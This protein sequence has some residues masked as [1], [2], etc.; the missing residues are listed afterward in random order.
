MLPG[1]EPQ[2]Q[3]PEENFLPGWNDEEMQMPQATSVPQTQEEA[4]L[5]GFDEESEEED[6]V[7]PGLERQEPEYEKPVVP[8][9]NV[10]MSNY[11]TNSYTSNHYDA[12]S[13]ASNSMNI[14]REEQENYEEID[15]SNLL[16]PDRKIVTFVGTS[17]NGTSF[18]VNNIAELMSSIGINTAILDTTQNRNSYYI[19]TK[20][21]ESLR[22]IAARSIQGLAMRN[23]KWN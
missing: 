10:N 9:S 11:E 7:L 12:N 14:N 8:Q 4:F 16:T 22:E 6:M 23:S 17:K 15:L 1:L 3:E 19:Y 5:P 13:Y 18:I 20:N 2:E 21:E